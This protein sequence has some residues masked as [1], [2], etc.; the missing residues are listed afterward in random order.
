MHVLLGSLLGLFL[1]VPVSAI[2]Y[3]RG[4][5]ALDASFVPR[6]EK[7][8]QDTAVGT[9]ALSRAFHFVAIASESVAGGTYGF[10]RARKVS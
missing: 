1:A 6:A 5:G 7:V 9:G 8:L 2:R 4:A 10:H 3:R